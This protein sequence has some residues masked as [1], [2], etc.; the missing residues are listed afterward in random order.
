MN[1]DLKK[2]RLVNRLVIV[3][4]FL[5]LTF[6]TMEFIYLYLRSLKT[7]PN[8]TGTVSDI[9]I[10]TTNII[11][12]LCAV[13]AFKNI[14][15]LFKDKI[16]DRAI[17]KIDTAL[18]FLDESIEKIS[19][20]YFNLMIAKIYKNG[21]NPKVPQL[22]KQLNDASDNLSGALD[23]AYKAKS[24]FGSLSRWNISLETEQGKRKVKLVNDVFELC[25]KST[26][27]Y[28]TLIKEI[29]PNSTFI[30]DKTFETLFNEFD[31]ERQ[32]LE[33][34]SKALKN[35]SIHQIFTIK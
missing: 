2:T 27:M 13:F 24:A 8:Y 5:L 33:E 18:M 16:S 25:M 15:S 4:V 17:N 1:M 6:A 9:L 3:I 20:L 35:V 32:R 14:S 11:L 12:S 23:A 19:S 7:A 29:N 34:E 22:D 21:S 26:T 31:V 10:A 30:S 28:S